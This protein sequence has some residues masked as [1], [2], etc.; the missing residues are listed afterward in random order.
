MEV[1][2]KRSGVMYMAGAQCAVE[3]VDRRVA[4]GAVGGRRLVVG[5]WR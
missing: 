5:G 1:P 2:P 4:A 3:A